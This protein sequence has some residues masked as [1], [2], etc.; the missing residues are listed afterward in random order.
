MMEKTWDY[1]EKEIREE[2]AQRI[3]DELEGMLPP[4]D[5]TEYA[6][7]NAMEWVIKLVRGEV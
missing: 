5:D 1:R 2:I 4:V 7:F 6:V 3:E